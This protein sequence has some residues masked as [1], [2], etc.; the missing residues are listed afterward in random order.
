M[1]QD[2]FRTAWLECKMQEDF[3]CLSKEEIHSHLC[4]THRGMETGSYK[5]KDIEN[6]LFPYEP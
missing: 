1:G 4:D 3:T 6:G 2:I 5:L